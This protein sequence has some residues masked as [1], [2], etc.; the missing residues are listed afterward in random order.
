[1]LDCNGPAKGKGKLGFSD[2]VYVLGFNTRGRDEE[3][4]ME[5]GVGEVAMQGDWDGA[6]C[7]GEA[8]GGEGFLEGDAIEDD[9]AVEVGLERVVVVIQGE[10]EAPG[11]G[12]G[13]AGDAG[14]GLKGEGDGRTRQ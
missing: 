14:V 11:G 10:K 13:E 6:P 5:R 7:E 4:S 3:I 1:M 9:A 8:D 2:F 12:G